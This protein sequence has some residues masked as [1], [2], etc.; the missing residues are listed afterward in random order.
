MRYK[1]WKNAVVN[2]ECWIIRTIELPNGVSDR[3]RRLHSLEANSSRRG[4]RVAHSIVRPSVRNVYRMSTRRSIVRPRGC[5]NGIMRYLCLSRNPKL[6]LNTYA[7]AG[8]NDM[9]FEQRRNK[10]RNLSVEE[11]PILPRVFRWFKEVSFERNTRCILE[12]GGKS[13][14]TVNW[15]GAFSSIYK[16][17]FSISKIYEPRC[18]SCQN[19]GRNW[20]EYPV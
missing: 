10:R 13:D 18:F 11:S 5:S 2:A 8:G 1:F 20:A 6:H 16:F 12:N 19:F 15:R 14:E 3:V 4:N 9:P 17:F 7:Y